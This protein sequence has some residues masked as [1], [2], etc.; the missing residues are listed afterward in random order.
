ML[1]SQ[2]TNV[3]TGSNPASSVTLFPIVS[4]E[5][6]QNLFSQPYI[7][8]AGTGVQENIGNPSITVS[9]VTNTTEAMA[10]SI[11]KSFKMSNTNTSLSYTFNTA[12]SSPAYKIIT[13]IK[14]DSDLPIMA[15]A[16]AKG[17]ASQFGSSTVDINAFGYMK[18]VTYV[19]S[20]GPTDTI[21][22]MKYTINLNTYN[23]N[24]I[25]TPIN[26]YYTQPEVFPISYYSY[27][28]DS[29]WPTD[30]P[31]G[32][33][34]PG[35]S[36]V[37]TGNSSVSLP[38]NF[39]QISTQTINGKTGIYPP[40]SPI[41]QNPHFA[42]ATPPTPMYKNVM[43][44]D[45]A[46][47]KYFVSDASAN[48]PNPSISG[49]YQP[50]TNANKI[51]LK[52]NT[53]QSIPTINV[54]L[55]GTAIA[56]GLVVPSNGVVVLYYNGST[57][58]QNKWS[59]MPSF[60]NDGTISLLKS[61]SKITVTQTSTT[62][63][64]DFASYTSSAYV[65]SDLTRMQVIE[66]SPRI[67]VD[68]T[69]YVMDL[70]ITKQLDSKNN[71]I[72]ISSINPN[73]A[74]ITLSGIPLTHNNS[75]VPIFSSQNQGSVLYNMMKKNIKIYI[76][77]NLQE[78][79]QGT[80]QIPNAFIPAGIYWVDTWTETDI[81]TIKVSC[82][83]IVN[84]LQTLPAPDYVASNKS[85]FD[86]LTNVLDL[87]GFTDYDYDSLYRVTND[88]YTEMDL[89]YYYCNSQSVTLYDAISELFL[90]HQIG[91]Y[92][93]EFGIMKFLS[94]SD[95][96]RAKDSVV[97][98]NDASI[99]QGGY[100]ITNKAKPGAIT[101]SYQEPK[102][103]QSLALQNATDPSVQKS[104]SF[105]YTTSNEVLWTQK[106]PDSVGANYLSTSMNESDNFFQMNNNSLL[107]VFHTYL[108]N[109]DGYAAI[110]NEIVSFIYKEYELKQISTGITQLV[111]PKNDL[112]LSSAIN[113]FIKLHQ[114]KLVTSDGSINTN[115]LD[116]KIT[117]TGKIGNV[118][119]GM[120]G[121]VAS[122]HNIPSNISEKNLTSV[123]GGTSV[124]TENLASSD[125][126][127]ISK[128]ATV[129]NSNAMQY[130]YNNSV[131]NP[132]Y[133]TY[134]AKFDLNAVS[135]VSGGVFFSSSDTE[136]RVE[137]VQVGNSLATNTYVVAPP[138]PPPY[139]APP[140]PPPPPVTPPPPPPPYVAPPPPPPPYVA[141]PPPPPPYTVPPQG[142]FPI[143]GQPT[144]YTGV[145]PPPPP[146]PYVAPP[147]P[148][149]PA[150]PPPPPPP[151]YVAPPPPPPPYV[152]P[153][154]PPPPYVAPPPPPP[155]Y[156]AP[157]PPPPPYVA[158][159][160]PPPPV[161]PPPP[162]PP[163]VA[164]PP[165]PPPQGYNSGT[166]SSSQKYSYFITVTAKNLSSG[167][168][169]MIAMAEVD[170]IV[171]DVQARWE[172]VL[173]KVPGN[174]SNNY[175]YSVATDQEYNLKVVTNFSDGTDGEIQGQIIDVYLNNIQITGWQIPE[176][177]SNNAFVTDDGVTASRSWKSPNKN[178]IT[179]LVQKVNILNTSSQKLFTGK[180]GFC[181]SL[182][183]SIPGDF[184]VG[185]YTT[186]PPP[187]P[188]GYTP[189]PPPP[190]VGYNPPPPPPPPYVAPP[191]PP[192]PYTVPPQGGFPI[193]GQPTIYT[194]VTPPPPPP[195][196]YVAPPP[197]PPPYV[198]PP[199]PP[200]PYVAPPPPPPPYVAPPPPP[201][202]A[203]PPPPPPP[204]PPVIQLGNSVSALLREIYACE[205]AL[206]Q[207]SANYW[208]QDSEFL[209]G[210]VQGQNI[211]SRYRSYMM[212]VTPEVTGINY[213]DVQYQTPAATSA[214]VLPIEYLWFYFPGDQPI[215]QQY[216]QQQL[217]D[218]YSL[219]YSTPIN[220]GFRARLAIAN[221][222]GHMVYLT[223]QSDSINQFTVALNLWT[224]ELVAPS[225]PQ[226]LH[227]VIDRANAREVIQ[228]DSP[229]IQSKHSANRL[230]D[231]ITVGNDGFSKDTSV[232]IFGNP[233]IQVGDIVTMDYSLAGIS[234]AK[235]LVHQVSHTFNKGLKTTLTLNSLNKSSNPTNM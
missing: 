202:P 145:T 214:D 117:P 81:Q 225:D 80:E 93:D 97:G 54:L 66:I 31:F 118:Q 29:L 82:F 229:W 105:V 74:S 146:P 101:I 218:E 52:F 86:I 62:P 24:S 128:I 98:F 18:L 167:N 181:T 87:A 10:G 178:T 109:T 203:T 173:T 235:Y 183:P 1:N 140:P 171:A 126:P 210:M 15:N 102:V 220:T 4:A 110:E 115:A 143:S 191:P 124:I 182:S 159:P 116:V 144:I 88:S 70:D 175:T 216:Y 165:P 68:L 179:G 222:I 201:P 177:N 161:T 196:P 41:T 228:V 234:G 130:V 57:W 58:S 13:Y 197:P 67:E 43:P 199:P 132:G 42:L 100:S 155:P 151:P 114:I 60:N 233:L 84:Y 226:T 187:P 39:R 131:I 213:Y 172:K 36:Y 33:F 51:V 209:N 148:P 113:Q 64:S 108:L 34:R 49:I 22:S 166:T 150:T 55:D 65:A 176:T 8:V 231:I 119:R 32:F 69:P 103:T 92:I 72:P 28:N 141:P 232:Q 217:V 164:P 96:I 20:S 200:P 99:I 76:N 91:A 129:P 19:G 185:S 160:P 134:S 56:T 221:N 139:V 192:P 122:T 152:A 78:Y 193:S 48:T 79:F 120:F 138:P 207:R 158:P 89:Y 73:D 215:D 71:Y 26:V 153:P 224:H 9:D 205:K 75:P 94:L 230:I 223:H 40:V 44:S 47:Y 11:T 154:P 53:I 7:T 63:T 206:N 16:Y 149:P 12:T 186:P 135:P 104:P 208:Y 169:S 189:P 23:S 61:F 121:T 112:E 163:Y 136:Y 107:D 95:I 190:P 212:Q 168:S 137:L 170:G 180:F 174:S 45:M 106:D 30:S 156:V 133:K 125:N 123:Q 127:V 142:G 219:S 77:W 90:A 111:Y 35:E 14:T 50:N 85:I 17:S 37:Q 27:Q 157:P 5:W 162:P 21:S 38:S 25:S 188:P 59:T 83:D 147:P 195:P 204:P 198:A 184:V 211:F 3:F 6:N 46:P 2:Y 227:R 194:G